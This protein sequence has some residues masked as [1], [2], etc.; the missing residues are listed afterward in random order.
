VPFGAR[1][2][3]VLDRFPTTAGRFA[4]LDRLALAD[5]VDR[6]QP[7]TASPAELWLALPGDALPGD[8]VTDNPGAGD[9][10]AGGRAGGDPVASAGALG[11]VL[12]QDR[13][14]LERSLRSDP[15]ARAA[16]GLLVAGAA[17]S[18]AVA[19]VALV[20][21]VAA[22]RTDEAAASYAW[23]ADGVPPATL[24]AGLW[25]RAAAVAGPAV[26]LGVLAG[27]ALSGLTGRLVSIT[28]TATAPV[29]PLQPGTGLG[30][31]LAV[32]LGGLLAAL[33]LAAV[34]AGRSL[35]EPLPVR[36]TGWSS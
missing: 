14:G 2:V 24:R 29:P 5:L 10:G 22:E 34:V 31:G 12:V 13:V 36:R 35:R 33:L 28:A 32:V 15:V 26:P 27:V 17:F 30:W 25:W 21:L 9:P 20:L 6:T 16:T 8:A 3:A 18:L 11:S 1:V 4:L 23:E 7:G 19:L